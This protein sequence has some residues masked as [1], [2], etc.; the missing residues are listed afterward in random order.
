MYG[1]H[2]ISWGNYNFPRSTNKIQFFDKISTSGRICWLNEGL[3][4][5]T[6]KHKY[7]HQILGWWWWGGVQVGGG[8][9]YYNFPRSTNKIKSFDKFLTSAKIIFLCIFLL[10]GRVKV[11]F[12]DRYEKS[13]IYSKNSSSYQVFSSNSQKLSL[14][15][16]NK[17]IIHTDGFVWPT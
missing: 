12:R 10:W 7:E 15:C 16:K 4:I 5:W 8:V 14:W 11:N 2:T 6:L 17:L 13:N 9:G 1:P 3:K